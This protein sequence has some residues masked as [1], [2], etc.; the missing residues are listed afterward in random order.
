MGSLIDINALLGQENAILTGTHV[1]YTS[2]KHGSAYVDK[3]AFGHKPTIK[4]QIGQAL[5]WKIMTDYIGNTCNPDHLSENFLF[6]GPETY[7][8]DYA[9]LAAINYNKYSD[10]QSEAI[11]CEVAEDRAFFSDKR[12]F[13]QLVSRRKIIYVDDILNE[14]STY[15][16]V[17]RLIEECGGEI[18][19]VLAIINRQPGKNTAKSLGVSKLIVLKEVDMEVYDS[20]ACPLC[21]INAPMR[22]RPG[23]GKEWLEKHPGYPKVE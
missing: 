16:K 2:G 6:I 18:V 20:D 19:L 4:A 1:V 22:E 10:A 8:R 3:D 13:D 23:H 11:F 9:L 7:G 5:A 12:N 17:K 14:A 15:F 21:A